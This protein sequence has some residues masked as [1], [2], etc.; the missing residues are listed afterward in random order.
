MRRWLASFGGGGGEADDEPEMA[1]GGF[2]VVEGWRQVAHVA[3][4][5]CPG[6]VAIGQVQPMSKDWVLCVKN[7]K[8]LH[9]GWGLNLHS[10][11]YTVC[12]DM[13]KEMAACGTQAPS[14]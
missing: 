6:L 1:L 14:S 10:L 3:P 2:S 8:T 11:L 7:P 4:A 13:G 9:A 5:C 12:V